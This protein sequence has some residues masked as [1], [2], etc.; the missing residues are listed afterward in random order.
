MNCI[1]LPAANFLHDTAHINALP[2]I[3]HVNNVLAA[4]VGDTLKIG[5]LGGH[6]GT[7]VIDDM[8]SNRIHLRD[9]QLS[10]APPA[11]LDLPVS[12]SNLA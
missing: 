6:L 1:L 12:P 7:A 2:Q 8:T 4:K 10:I 9:V 11:K 5:Q 3:D